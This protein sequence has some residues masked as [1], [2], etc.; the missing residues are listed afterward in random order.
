MKAKLINIEVLY[1]PV[2]EEKRSGISSYP[3]AQI[4]G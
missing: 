4:P 1:I 3:D 2:K